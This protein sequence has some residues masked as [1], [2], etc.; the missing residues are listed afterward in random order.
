MLKFYYDTIS[1]PTNKESAKG[2]L[3]CSKFL[4]TYL[5]T[6]D[7]TTFILDPKYTSRLTV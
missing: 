6:E 5:R 7:T 2:P 3:G 4:A 1:T